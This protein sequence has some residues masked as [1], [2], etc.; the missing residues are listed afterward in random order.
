MK[1][2]RIMFLMFAALSIASCSSDDGTED[3]NDWMCR[4]PPDWGGPVFTLD[5]DSIPHFRNMA[6]MS[7]YDFWQRVVGKGWHCNGLQVINNDG[8]YSNDN[9]VGTILGISAP[10]YYFGDKGLL[11]KYFIADSQGS[12][13]HVER[14]YSYNAETGNLTTN[15]GQEMCIFSWFDDTEGRHF[16]YGIWR[17]GVK[18]SGVPTYCIMT[19]QQMTQQELDA[20]RREYAT[21]YGDI[22]NSDAQGKFFACEPV[23]DAATSGDAT[24]VADTLF[25]EDDIEWFN[26]T[27]REL[28]FKPQQEPLYKRLAKNYERK[29]E[30]R[31]G[32]RLLFPV[33]HF[34]T[35]ADSRNYYSLVLYY[36]TT[37]APDI[38]HGTYYLHDCY[39]LQFIDTEEV[40]VNIKENAWRWQIFI[41]YL[42]TIGKLRK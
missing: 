14:P 11:T 27:T 22:K 3:P 35:D 15:D 23:G 31:L 10:H 16:L 42:S 4:L 2:F 39:P 30:F 1:I 29:L 8:S 41:S 28:K 25:T 24:S 7:E 19:L 26:P 18:A 32:W 5:A 13:M 38:D 12:L 21:A 20:T 36:K 6:P 34:V 40:K 33:S 37:D 17:M 9:L